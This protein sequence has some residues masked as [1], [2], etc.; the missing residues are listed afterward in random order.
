MCCFTTH[1]DFLAILARL[2]LSCLTYVSHLLMQNRKRK[3]VICCFNNR[4]TQ[5]KRAMCS[6]SKSWFFR[7]LHENNIALNIRRILT[8]KILCVLWA[9]CVFAKQNGVVRQQAICLARHSN[10]ILYLFIRAAYLREVR[11][12]LL[13]L[14]GY[15]RKAVKVFRV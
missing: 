9:I 13:K 2:P 10:I 1:N 4:H 8:L 14:Y 11:Q 15:T 3:S 7:A 6:S 5:S 12:S